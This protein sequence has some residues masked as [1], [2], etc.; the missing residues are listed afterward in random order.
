MC[1]AQLMRNKEWHTIGTDDMQCIPESF[2]C[3]DIEK[4][5]AGAIKL[6]EDFTVRESK[7]SQ[8]VFVIKN[9]RRERVWVEVPT[10]MQNLALSCRKGSFCIQSLIYL[11][12]AVA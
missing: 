4:A 3:G 10:F 6:F 9:P 2:Y 7:L 1:E 5:K 12:E 8:A 11:I